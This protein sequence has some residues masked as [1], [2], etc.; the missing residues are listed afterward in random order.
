MMAEQISSQKTK[1]IPTI[2]AQQAP[3]DSTPQYLVTLRQPL[4]AA[5][6]NRA[7]GKLLAETDMRSPKT[8]RPTKITVV[9]LTGLLLGLATV[10]NYAFAQDSSAELQNI[11]ANA[12]RTTHD[13]WSVDEVILNDNLNKAFTKKCHDKLPKVATAELNWRLLNMRKAGTL[14][15]KTTRSGAKPSREHFA[16]AEMVARSLIDQH[17][18]TVDQIMTDPKFR[19]QF[20]SQTT[21]LAKDIDTYL[22]RKAAFGLRK[23][24]HLRP[25]LIARI[26]DWGRTVKEFPLKLVEDDPELIPHQPGIYIFRDTSGYL[27]IGQSVDLNKRLKEHLNNSSNFSLSKYLIEQAHENM[28]LEIHAF[29][30]DSRAKETM[31]RRAYESELIASRKPKFNVQP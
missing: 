18:V 21:A 12:F 24:R 27:Y 14:K 20:D 16:V 23:K 19:A 17:G 2:H 7:R 1:R 4:P 22:V 30:V 28:T 11:V 10:S 15:T 29:P 8:T 13:G 6:P 9:L 26:A 5:D 25:E 31:V 3:A